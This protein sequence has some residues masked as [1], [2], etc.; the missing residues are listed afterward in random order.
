MFIDV[1]KCIPYRNSSI[2][3]STIGIN[4]TTIGLNSLTIGIL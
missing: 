4:S 2:N 1:K 3:E